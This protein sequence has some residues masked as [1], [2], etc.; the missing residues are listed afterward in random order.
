MCEREFFVVEL[1]L[2]K[3]EQMPGMSVLATMETEYTT[4]GEL[5]TNSIHSMLAL[6]GGTLCSSQRVT[7]QHLA[8]LNGSKQYD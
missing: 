2:A 8:L 7:S 5:L 3:C 6:V 4:Q 1:P